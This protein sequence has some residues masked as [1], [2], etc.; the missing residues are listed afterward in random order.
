MGDA[1]VQ[2]L[3][4]HWKDAYIYPVSSG[5][6][7]S[8][9][10]FT[11]KE[12]QSL[13]P[14]TLTLTVVA[15]I[16]DGSSSLLHTMGVAASSATGMKLAPT[17][18]IAAIFHTSTTHCRQDVHIAAAS[19]EHLL[20]FTSTGFVVQ[21]KLLPSAE[22]DGSPKFQP[23][24][25]ERTQDEVFRVNAEPIQWWDVCRRSDHPERGE[26]SFTTTFDGDKDPAV[27]SS[28]MV[29]LEN[30]SAGFNKSV[31]KN[32]IKAADRSNWYLS[33]AEVQMHSA[34]S[35]IWRNF[36]VRVAILPCLKLSFLFLCLIL[37]FHC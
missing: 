34:R 33:N 8:T 7:W 20:V 11:L 31:K 30:E 26:C 3:H 17:G 25:H 18:A 29:F 35:Q 4:S 22:T 5:P 15:R 36:K 23:G 12:H 37:I 24:P 16:K 28:R 27:D 21:H 32:T 14:S 2:S 1:N 19:L 13:H 10:S 9:S 6:W